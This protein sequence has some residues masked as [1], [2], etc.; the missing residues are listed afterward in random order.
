MYFIL[1]FFVLICQRLVELFIAKS[2]EEWMKR[3][4]ARE[5]GKAHYKMMVTIHIAFFVSLL[6]EGGFFHKGVNPFWPLLLTGFLLTQL[7]RIWV[8]SSLG[9]YWN[10]KIIVLPEAEAVSKGPYKYLKHPNYLI[11]TV[12]FLIVPLL[13]NAYWTLFIFALL[14]QFILAVRI[15]LEEQALRSETD[16]ERIHLQTKGWLPIIKKGK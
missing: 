12:E 4:G 11:V 8:M 3:Q 6:I 9:R 15:P 14:N 2:N 16:Y 5:Y 1:F 13:F 7:G 10:T